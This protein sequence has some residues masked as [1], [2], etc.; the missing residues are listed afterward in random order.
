VNQRFFRADSACY[1]QKV[2]RWLADEERE[3]G[4]AGFIGF[5]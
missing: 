2:L 1:D 4:P 3:C 5:S